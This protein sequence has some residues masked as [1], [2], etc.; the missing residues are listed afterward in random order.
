M[1]NSKEWW[2]STTVWFNLATVLVI[3]L[4]AIAENAG[5]LNLSPQVVTILG[6]IVAAINAFLRVF[7]TSQPITGTPAAKRLK[8]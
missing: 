7:K 2:Q 3:L 6:I 5:V 1:A 4:G 8:T